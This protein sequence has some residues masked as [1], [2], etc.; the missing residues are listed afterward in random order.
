MTVNTTRPTLAAL[1]FRL[2][3]LQQERRDAYLYS[4]FAMTNGTI[5]RID[6]RI[7]EVRQ[8]IAER[9]LDSVD[10]FH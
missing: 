2:A 10:A 3:D 8:Q 1:N 4:D 5:D 6:D 9:A 7:Y